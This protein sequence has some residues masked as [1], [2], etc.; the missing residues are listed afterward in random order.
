[1][2][3]YVRF[4]FIIYLHKSHC[5]NLNS[6]PLLLE[7]IFCIDELQCSRKFIGCSSLCSLLHSALWDFII[8]GIQTAGALSSVPNNIE[9]VKFIGGSNLSSLLHSAL[10]DLIML[11]I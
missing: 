4:H 10:W 2:F 9:G 8:L 5:I 3:T 7:I 6:K 11:G 1:M